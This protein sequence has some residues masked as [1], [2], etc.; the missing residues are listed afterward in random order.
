MAARLEL[1][2]SMRWRHN[3]SVWTDPAMPISI[4]AIRTK[5]FV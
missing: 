1:G 5:Q 2:S 4:R 3:A